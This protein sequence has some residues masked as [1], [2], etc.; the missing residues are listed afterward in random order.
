MLEIKENNPFKK[1]RIIFLNNEKLE[2]KEGHAQ[3]RKKKRKTL[4]QRNQLKTF[5]AEEANKNIKFKN[6]IDFDQNACNSI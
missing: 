5:K 1:A 4:I 2:S 6:I 3:M